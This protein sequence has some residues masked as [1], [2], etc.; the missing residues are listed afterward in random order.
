[1]TVHD[2]YTALSQQERGAKVTVKANKLYVGG[3]L[4]KV[5]GSEDAGDEGS[6][7]DAE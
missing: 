4:L 5:E 7:G 6:E 1:M 2:L 3:K